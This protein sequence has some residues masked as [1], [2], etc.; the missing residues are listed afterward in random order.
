MSYHGQ[1]LNLKIAGSRDALRPL[2]GDE[3][4]AFL[5]AAMRERDGYP[6][7]AVKVNNQTLSLRQRA[8]INGELAP[9]YLN[10]REGLT[11][12]R[13]SLCFLTEMAFGRLFPEGDLVIDHSLGNGFYY[14]LEGDQPAPE[15]LVPRLTAEMERIVKEDRPVEISNMSYSETLEM[16]K[17][18]GG[19]EKTIQL[20]EGLNK[21]SITIV[22]CEGYRSLFHGPLVPRTGLLQH[23]ELLKYADGFLLRFPPSRTPKEMVPF[24]DEPK[25]FSIY[26]EHK[27]WGKVMG[28]HCVGQ[29]NAL[30]MDK[31]KREHF[32]LAAETL[33]EQKMS[34]MA[35][36]IRNRKGVK[37]VLVAGPSSSGK[38]TFT[39]RMA[40]NLQAQGFDPVMIS[41]DDYYLPHDQTCL[42][43]TSPSPRD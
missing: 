37:I 23:W 13:H 29:L 27:K 35:H 17:N 28:I 30:S 24:R 43:Y 34:D 36:E 25:L 15:E 3:F 21:P 33:Q 11:L 16:L 32:I 40:I 19:A 2:G 7:V 6:L 42:L 38:T 5:P 39:K 9:V 18:R 12:Y 14:H 41:L 4:D 31:K 22:E 8:D 26:Q 20:M 1:N 10:D